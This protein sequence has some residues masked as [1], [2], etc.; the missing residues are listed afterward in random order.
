MD[1]CDSDDETYDSDIW[2]V[3]NI[4]E[5]CKICTNCNYVSNFLGFVSYL[6]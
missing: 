2:I 6:Q 1:M 5:T 3:M 4:S